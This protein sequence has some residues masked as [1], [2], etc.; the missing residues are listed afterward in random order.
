MGEYLREYQRRRRDQA[1]K[2][3][4]LRRSGV[5]GMVVV[6]AVLGLALLIAALVRLSPLA[7]VGALLVL[8]SATLWLL[9]EQVREHHDVAAARVF[10]D[11][12]EVKF[13]ASAIVTFLIALLLWALGMV[14]GW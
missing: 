5:T 14:K 3:G 8:G 13:A 11:L 4:R 9:S 10:R 7:V 6:L 12:A 2:P 1:S